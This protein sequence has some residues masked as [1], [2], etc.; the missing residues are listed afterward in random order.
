MNEFDDIIKKAAQSIYEK[1]NN[2]FVNGV[3]F[4]SISGLDINRVNKQLTFFIDECDAPDNLFKNEVGN[5]EIIIDFNGEIISCRYNYFIQ[6]IPLKN[7]IY[8]SVELFYNKN[9]ELINI[10][11]VAGNLESN[12][13]RSIKKH[14]YIMNEKDE[15]L[16]IKIFLNKNVLKEH[17][18]LPE[19]LIH[20]VYDFK[21]SDFLNRLSLFEMMID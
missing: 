9:F 7:D 8:N 14:P 3:I 13:F 16:L 17:N 15:F 20:G 6:S 1:F 10:N 2:G 11:L 21:S 12:D 5:Y 19:F 4:N 18:I